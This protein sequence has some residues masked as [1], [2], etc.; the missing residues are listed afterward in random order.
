M[1][2]RFRCLRTRFDWFVASLVRG[3]RFVSVVEQTQ[4]EKASN[5][6]AAEFATWMASVDKVNDEVA[7][8][9]GASASNV[10]SN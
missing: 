9:L 6:I 5:G 10:K 1:I 4:T 3:E 7:S 2:A 8:L